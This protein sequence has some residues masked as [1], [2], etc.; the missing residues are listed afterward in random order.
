MKLTTK[1]DIT[2]LIKQDEYM[3]TILHTVKALHLPDWWVCAGFVRAKVWDT[4]HQY[5]ERTLLPGIDVIY[6]DQ[7]NLSENIEEE[8]EAQLQ[9]LAPSIP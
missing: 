9:R 5:S 6:F 3:M 2:D 1:Q 7:Q 8:Y 4:L